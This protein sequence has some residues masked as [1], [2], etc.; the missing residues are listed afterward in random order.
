MP[1]EVIR[2]GMGS[3]EVRGSAVR[4]A[5]SPAHIPIGLLA[6]AVV[7]RRIEPGQPIS[8]DDVVIPESLALRA[9]R[10]IV[11]G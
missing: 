11:K 6:D 9:W 5:E 1:G 8:F 4:I 2:R 7:K 3:F 10:E